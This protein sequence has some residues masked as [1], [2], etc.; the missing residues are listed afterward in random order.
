MGAKTQERAPSGV[1]DLGVLLQSTDTP[2][3]YFCYF[4][5]LL[6]ESGFCWETSLVVRKSMALFIETVLCIVLRGPVLLKTCYF[7]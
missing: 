3:M 1:L 6:I 4:S 5:I 2:S 7:V